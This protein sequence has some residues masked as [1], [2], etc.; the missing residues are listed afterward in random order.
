MGTLE[1]VT[2]QWGYIGLNSEYLSYY[3]NRKRQ[4]LFAL[5]SAYLYHF[6]TC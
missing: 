1:L 6:Q 2:Q 4:V 5:F 3:K